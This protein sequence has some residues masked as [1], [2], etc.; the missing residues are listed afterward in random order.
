MPRT[1]AE[2]RAAFASCT[3]PDA[4]FCPIR[5]ISAA[6]VICRLSAFKA[7]ATTE[8]RFRLVHRTRRQYSAPRRRSSRTCGIVEA[9]DLPVNADFEN[10]FGTDPDGV[11]ESVRLAVDTGVAGLSIEDSTGDAVARSSRSVS[12]WSG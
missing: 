7:L 1:I 3:L 12:P 11:A 6:L 9:T 5:G 10:G 2:K 4:S 8:F